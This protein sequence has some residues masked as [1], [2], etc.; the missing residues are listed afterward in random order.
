MVMMLDD[1]AG[2][3]DVSLR[4][5]GVSYFRVGFVWVTSRVS[6]SAMMAMVTS[7]GCLYRF[8]ALLRIGV[9]LLRDCLF[10][11][12]S[13]CESKEN[14]KVEVLEFYLRAL[15]R[16]VKLSEW[17]MLVV[18][19]VSW[20]WAAIGV[21]WGMHGCVSLVMHAVSPSCQCGF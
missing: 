13:F 17:F 8:L 16:E 6:R 19:W 10:S 9:K 3:V 2:D 7:L 11:F 12:F 21:S 4:V 20:F 14:V 5:L 18:F 1:G 15:G